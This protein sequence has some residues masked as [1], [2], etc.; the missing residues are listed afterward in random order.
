M[1]SI[2]CIPPYCL[3]LKSQTVR[4]VGR[5]DD[6]HVMLFDDDV[7]KDLPGRVDDGGAGVVR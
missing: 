4:E 1:A 3:C 5:R 2:G 7:G 6:R